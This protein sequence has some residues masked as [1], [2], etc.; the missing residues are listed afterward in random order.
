VVHDLL[1]DWSLGIICFVSGVISIK[2]GY[3]ASQEVR[4]VTGCSAASR[5]VRI[6]R[7][8]LFGHLARRPDKEDHHRVL[9]A[10]TSNPPTGW[11]RPQEDVPERLGWELFP[12]ICSTLQ[13][14]PPLGLA[15]CCRS[16]AW[17][18]LIDTAIV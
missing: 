16:S 9:V 12:E 4:R 15:S 14:R 2:V 13:S 8:Q 1:L 6:R 11:R 7:L 3:E 5:L 17:H 10:A 18:E